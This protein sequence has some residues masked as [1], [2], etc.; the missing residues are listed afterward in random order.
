MSAR[1]TVYT[2]ISPRTCTACLQARVAARAKLVE[3]I[4]TAGTCYKFQIT[5]GCR[6]VIYFACIIT[7]FMPTFVAYLT[8]ATLA[9]YITLCTRIR[10]KIMRLIAS[11]TV[12]FSTEIGVTPSY[13]ALGMNKT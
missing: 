6:T 9:E 8:S 5:T 3:T 7:V 10:Y 11:R 2:G 13:G 1:K 12:V 4:W